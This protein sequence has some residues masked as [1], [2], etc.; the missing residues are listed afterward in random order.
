MLVRLFNRVATP[1]KHGASAASVEMA[2]PQ[3]CASSGCGKPATMRCPTCR[4]LGVKAES[5]FCGKVSFRANCV[6]AR[7]A[8]YVTRRSEY[9][10]RRSVS[11]RRLLATGFTLQECFQ[12]TWNEQYV[13]WRG[14]RG[15]PRRS[16]RKMSNAS[17]LMPSPAKRVNPHS[18]PCLSYRPP[19]LQQAG[20]QAV[21]GGGSAGGRADGVPSAGRCAQVRRAAV[22]TSSRI[23][24]RLS[25]SACASHARRSS[26]SP[27]RFP[28]FSALLTA[29][30][31]RPSPRRRL[32]KGFEGFSFTG[33]LRP[34]HV[35]PMMKVP[36]NI[37]KPDY[38][39][40]GLP[41][42]EIAERGSNVIPLHTPE[43]LAAIREAC[44]IGRHVLDLAAA[45]L[46]PGVTGEE[47][48]KLVFA[49]TVE[50]GGYPS[51]LNYHAFPKSFCM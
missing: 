30:S 6:R 13:A 43:Q 36:A 8:S 7:M 24:Q 16:R 31:S 47:I 40:A 4:E 49:A 51:T 50:R 11:H 18:M 26:Y 2:S 14:S 27:A 15:W 35:T 38:A 29:L 45:A 20:A 46:R 37:P 33:K 41:L 10:K 34:G 48:D 9:L 17:H 25:L 19:P 5:H 12:A 1:R 22:L 21:Q 42:S 44:A 39:D 28:L 32:P 3:L 23:A